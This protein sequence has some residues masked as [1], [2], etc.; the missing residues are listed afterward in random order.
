[1]SNPR[2][3]SPA[4]SGLTNYLLYRLRSS[5][6]RLEIVTNFC[7]LWEE[8]IGGGQKLGAE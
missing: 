8:L 6:W 3:L 2:V 7:D 1:M 5:W 4:H